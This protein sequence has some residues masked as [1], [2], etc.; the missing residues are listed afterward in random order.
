MTSP[1]SPE[2]ART[3]RASS[4]LLILIPSAALALFLLGDTVVRGSWGQMLLVAPWLLLA[5]WVL[6]E[7]SYVS[8]VRVSDDGVIVQNMLRR[9]SFGWARVRDIDLRW[10]LQFSLDDGRDLTCW[11]GPARSRPPRP[12]RGEDAEVKVPSGLRTLTD[13][14]DRWEAAPVADAPIRREWDVPAL[15]ALAVIIIWAVGS[16]AVVGAA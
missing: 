14:R 6:Y 11:G 5:L 12:G 2:G 4:G 1:Q 8:S 10:Q 9:T 13:I 16:V 7:I 15:I 3:Y